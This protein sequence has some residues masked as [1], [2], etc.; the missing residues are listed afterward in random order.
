MG[1]IDGKS[2]PLV[3]YTCK[4]DNGR[5]KEIT[6]ANGDKTTATYNGQSQMV[7]EKWYDA[8][9]TLTAHYK[10]VYD[11]V[12]NIVRSIDILSSKEYTYT[13]EEGWWK[14]CF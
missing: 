4:N 7:A 12:G 14:R 2:E 8:S 5:L 3:Q 9:N 10:Y 6:Y 11:T 1:G 13:Y